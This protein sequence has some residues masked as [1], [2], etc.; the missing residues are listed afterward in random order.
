MS[1]VRKVSV[2]EI[3]PLL[4][5]GFEQ[6]A[7]RGLQSTAMRMHSF[8]LTVLIPKEPRIPVDR[9][10]YRA[11]W[12]F[13]PEKKGAMVY[14]VAPHAAHVE[15]GV[16][17]E[18]VKA[19]KKMIEALTA[20]VIRKRIVKAKGRSPAAKASAE[21]EARQV[22]FAIAQSMKKKGIFNGGKGLRILARASEKIPMWAREEIALELKRMKL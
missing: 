8:I 11:G 19:G 15:W 22:A 18:N 3:G 6:V 1:V 5:K 2:D 7:V 4:K 17:A 21:A 12:R 14:N 10:I 13:K 20:W 16:P 9:G